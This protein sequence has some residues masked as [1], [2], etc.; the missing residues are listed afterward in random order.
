M[1]KKCLSNFLTVL[2][3]LA[4]IS[5]S[6]RDNVENTG[7]FSGSE[8]CIQCHE[9][10]YQLWSPSHH[11]KAMEPLN[12]DY[13]QSKQLGNSGDFVLEGKKYRLVFGDSTMTMIETDGTIEKEYPVVWALG[14]KNVSY[15]LTELDKG[16]LQTIPIAYDHNKKAWYN[17][18]ESAVRHFTDD[19]MPD[20]EALPWKDRM[21]TF[22]TSCYSCHVSQLETNFDETTDSYH[23]TWKE[24]GIN[25]ETCHGPSADHV[26]VMKTAEKK[27]K[28]PDDIK[29]IVT[30]TF[31]KEQH[32]ASCA[33][34]HA[35]MRPITPGYTPGDR[36]F[37]N[38]DLTTFENADFY[39]DGRDLGENYTYTQ[40]NQNKCM[41]NGEL[42]CVICHTSSGRDR[43]ADNPNDACLQCHSDRKEKLSD[44]T[45]HK[46]D[47]EGSVCINCHMPETQFG[48]MKR[49]DHSFRPPMPEA[50]IR[51]GSPNACNICHT[52]KTPEWAKQVLKERKKD[53]IQKETLK[54]AD[55]IQQARDE[56][57]KNLD[58]ML[59]VISEQ[60]YDAIVQN[61][62]IRILASC[63][64]KRKWP[65]LMD[66]TLNNPSPLVRASA[67]TGLMDNPTE[68]VKNTLIKAC[69]DDY[70]LVRIAAAVPL[71]SFPEEGFTLDEA[72][73]V[74]KATDEYMTSIV[75]R[76]DDWSSH[77]NL[78]IYYQ[79]KGETAQALKSYEEAAHLYP[80]SILPFINSS[81]LYSYI[82]NNEK[83]EQN[84]QEVLKMD[85]EN[86]A[87]NLNM[88]LLLAELG[89]LDEAEKAL[90]K[91][92][93]A[94][95]EGQ[96]VAA[97]NLS[98]IVGQRGDFDNAVKYA[99]IAWEIRSGEP[100]Y[101]YTLA[102]YQLQNNQKQ[103]AIKTLKK[104]LDIAPDY[105][106]A[107]QFLADIYM[108]DGQN[109][110]AA[111]QLK[112][113]LKLNNLSDQ[114]RT[115]FQQI[116]TSLQQN[117]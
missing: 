42:H 84:L 105:M 63:E 86:E 60:K 50:T 111:E 31:T 56:D 34:C 18:P 98:V 36:Y 22:N 82:G 94:N 37:D 43:Y 41:L 13:I 89:R 28:V 103:D 47:C 3:M 6:Q 90:K 107:R 78:G 49:H 96:A 33:P 53:N 20:D 67:A 71:G 117:M 79:N 88:G 110:Q 14:G 77:Y 114:E 85:P 26:R 91:A 12:A 115:Y 68:E 109:K 58:E 46:P 112:E 55:L 8:S 45:G 73:V 29:I 39:P 74:K 5:C 61:S 100:S 48:N 44:H 81:V 97:K 9:K 108:K 106:D 57:W 17:N 80:E 25:C 19:N 32:N 72:A 93:A 40:W 2:L 1:I 76:A 62:L 65:V 27:G 102:F 92:L 116:L 75:T 59:A 54:W 38:Y 30:K 21:Y 35:K 23:S 10:F 15:Y 7:E 66:A 113:I 87:A 69:S 52:D 24:P 70:R 4:G 83:A 95:P 51:Y 104:V 16:M 99:D 64:D 11:G 101:G